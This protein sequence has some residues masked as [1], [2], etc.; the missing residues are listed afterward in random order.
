MIIKDLKKSNN[1]NLYDDSLEIRKRSNKKFNQVILDKETHTISWPNGA[2]FAP[3]YLKA[4]LT[5]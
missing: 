2:D 4:N 1:S 5:K 3:E